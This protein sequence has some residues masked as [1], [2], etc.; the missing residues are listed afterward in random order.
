M[1]LPPFIRIC[2]ATLFAAVTVVSGLVSGAATAQS[3]ELRALFSQ[4]VR[5]ERPDTPD[6]IPM[7]VRGGKLFV[8]AAAN[9]IE[10]EFIFDTG[11]PTILSRQ[12]ADQLGLEPLGQNTGFDAN[13]N[14]VTMDIVQLDQLVIGHT[15][16]RDVP[17]LVFDFSSLA[18]GG[19]LI[20][21]G[22]IGSEILPG[23][24]WR[25]D[26]QSET[27]TIAATTD[28]LADHDPDLSGRLHDFGYPH[29]PIIDYQ[30][31]EISDR[32]LFDTGS[33]DAITLFARVAE[34]ASARARMVPGSL[35][36]GEGQE[37]ESAGG[38]GPTGPL[39]RFSLREF[40]L[41]GQAL[42]TAPATIRAVPP[43]L[44]G[45]GWLSSHVITL[46]YAGANIFFEARPEPAE[47]R[48][49]AGYAIAWV[50][51]HAEVVQLFEGSAAA[52]AGLRLGD[53]V[54]RL[55]DRSM[56]ADGAAVCNTVRWLF[57]DFNAG[58]AADIE[59]TRASGPVVIH[60]PPH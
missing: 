37:G 35:Q 17:V 48:V 45:A 54:V 23:S 12:L 26:A 7:E 36:R 58:D 21:G 46:D 14:P 11:S 49:D 3:A 51:D 34:S 52:Q 13:G 56:Q 42:P 15:V 60:V 19:C 18:T 41:S 20:G 31:G 59:V 8:P 38:R 25:I 47:P 1:S 39:A 22:V 44:L 4:P 40:E 53:H 50:D 43:T 29:A 24:V 28:A 33:A 6:A 30:L 9:G 57:A 2:A 5:L 10:Q 55:N 16:F 27:L 32:A